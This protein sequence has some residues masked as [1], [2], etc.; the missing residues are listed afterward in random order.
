MD[1][2]VVDARLSLSLLSVSVPSVC[3]CLFCL[4]PWPLTCA[5]FPNAVGQLALA[6][7]LG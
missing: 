4:L 7:A 5:L 2:A 6:A 1:E 3:L